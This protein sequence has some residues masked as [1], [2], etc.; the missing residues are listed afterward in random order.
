MSTKANV[1]ETL[2]QADIDRLR[3]GI[4]TPTKKQQL[5]TVGFTI[6]NCARLIGE[7]LDDRGVLGWFVHMPPAAENTSQKLTLSRLLIRRQGGETRLGTDP[8]VGLDGES[9]VDFK[10]FAQNAEPDFPTGNTNAQNASSTYLEAVEYTAG[11]LHPSPQAQVK[12]LSN[13]TNWSGACFF[14]RSDLKFMQLLLLAQAD[15]YN[16]LFFSGAKTRYDIMHNP[17]LRVEQ[18]TREDATGTIIP[19]PGRAFT[20][21]A[22]PVAN[23]DQNIPSGNEMIS[24][25]GATTDTDYS[26]RGATSGNEMFP[27]AVMAAPC[28]P[29]WG[30]I[31]KIGDNLN[32]SS[33]EAAEKL[34]SLIPEMEELVGSSE[35]GAVN[36]SLSEVIDSEDRDW[37]YDILTFFINLF[38]NWRDGGKN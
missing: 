2:T 32:L 10:V 8:I 6:Q 33:T 36:I 30:I 26:Q 23:P 19:D 37:L 31:Q 18:F 11:R 25:L 12:D 38:T 4:P 34:F 9:V 3:A 21:K 20:M 7:S 22:E 17:G 29:Y 13:Y 28:P 14:R 1:N 15:K 16:D 35:I 24:L 5:L 27:G